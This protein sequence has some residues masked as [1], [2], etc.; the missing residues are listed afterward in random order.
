MR[1]GEMLENSLRSVIK[2]CRLG[3]ILIQTN[4]RTMEPELYYL[5]L[6]KNISKYTI[7]LM[8]TTTATGLEI[9]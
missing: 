8:D 1:A 3:K 7:L 9:I 2:E 6:P 4:Q 5:R